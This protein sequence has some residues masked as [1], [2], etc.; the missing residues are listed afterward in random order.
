MPGRAR[1]TA[2][3]GPGLTR[4]TM[5]ASGVLAILVAL[6]FAVMLRAVDDLRDATNERAQVRMALV[7]SQ[8]LEQLVIDLE[9]SQRG[10][11]ITGQEDF[12]QPWDAARKA[13][14]AQTQAFLDRSV[15]PGLTGQA[16]QIVRSSESFLRDYSIPLVDAER[17][18][19][20]SAHGLATTAEGKRL[21][22]GLR[23]QFDRYDA[24]VG[25]A[26]AARAANADDNVRRAIIAA[27]VGLGGSVI[28]V[29]AFTWYLTR[30]IVRPV[31]RASALATRLADG[32]LSARMP[33]AG[34]NEL[35]DLG[36]AFNSMGRSLEE[37]R[38]RTEL[39][40]RRLQLLYEAS[41]AVGTTLDV[42][43]TAQEL[44]RVVVPVI[45]DFATVDLAVPVLS[46]E[47]PPADGDVTLRRVAVGGVR[48][49]PP[50]YRV[51][52]V[53]IMV[54]STLQAISLGSGRPMIEPDLRSATGWRA[55]DPQRAPRMLDYGL[56]SLIT[57]PLRARGVLMGVVSL[58]R[59][60][61]TKPFDE[62]ELSYSVELAAK[63]ALAID[64]ARRY[65]GER[66][67]ALALQRSL[68]PQR[69]PGQPAVEIASRYLPAG[70]QAGVGG[71]W[72]DVIPLS[73]A[74]VALVVGDVVGHGLHASATMG[75]LR[76]AVRTLAEV[77]LPPDELLTHLDDLVLH[78][79]GDE[80]PGVAEGD[81]AAVGDLGATCLYAVYDPVSR[82][83]T[84]ATAGHP[85]PVLVTPGG[86][87]EPLSG[88]IGPPLGIGGLPFE[89]TEVEVAEGSLLALFTDGLVE[90]RERDFDQGLAELCQTLAGAAV[91]LEAA[92]ETVIGGLLPD[93]PGDD[94]ALL[95]ARTRA[96]SP[97]QVATW[98]IP[99]DPA[100]VVRA[101]N[102]AVDQLEAWGLADAA[103]VTE[104]VVSELVT[105]AIR[106]GTPPIQLRLIRDRTLI[107][108]VSDASST[109]PHLRRARV[110][111]EGGRGL[112]LVAQ[113]TQGW[114]TRQTATGKTI[115]CEQALSPDSAGLSFEAAP[116]EPRALS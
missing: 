76:T 38:E 58:W 57:V 97:D 87:A 54:P 103:F 72:F 10:F 19:D 85:L 37:S 13:F 18:G 63:A 109:A 106:Y 46:G 93:R 111:D 83:C 112:L 31:R 82:C 43:R 36:T 79:T 69:L 115:W 66:A 78:L 8:A 50:L 91:S 15:E 34:A 77:D 110:F 62:D 105:N 11:V 64:N 28:L 102:L 81:A 88:H 56:H 26:L 95:L 80:Q 41:V 75:R 44:V 30:A 107:C 99:A 39:A 101:R 9:T 48:D 5:I 3:E 61:Q 86:T 104:L 4:L 114:G 49:D 100:H 16:R 89:A 35:R 108:E 53:I 24:D 59:W 22:D 70:S 17:R 42:E 90:S 74:R 47:E 67:T 51:G 33:E 94:V 116:P 45:A 1:A 98:D 52:E 60:R 40:R 84:L 2:G 96:L 32:D 55:Q 12:L 27:S 14:P 7:E 23:A 113:L 92:C 71:D 29:T 21:V 20:P 68:L 73:G 6:A 65:T 25:R